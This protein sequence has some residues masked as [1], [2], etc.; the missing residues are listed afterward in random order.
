MNILVLN[1]S[2][3]GDKSDCMVV[4]RAFLE[5]MGEKAEVLNIAKLD[6][7]PCIGCFACWHKTPGV[8]VHHDD[9][10]IVLDKI[11]KA[12]LVIYSMPLYCYG[13]PSGIKALTDRL[14]PLSTP[15]LRKGEDGLTHHPTRRPASMRFMLITGSGFPDIQNNFEGLLFQFGRMFG[16]GFPRITC[17]ESPLLNIKGAEAVT[18]PY[19]ALVA[20]AGREFAQNGAISAGTQTLLDT[21]MYDPDEYRKGNG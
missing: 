12:D 2:P 19:L 7:K 6:I 11:T 14:L 10:T 16:K 13:M 9:M 15:A 3:K 17:A 18:K 5:G 8:C 21:P 1:G 4:T 20:Q